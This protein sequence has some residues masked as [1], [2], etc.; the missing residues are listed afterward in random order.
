M[1]APTSDRKQQ[2]SSEPSPGSYSYVGRRST[3]PTGSRPSP[4][5]E[6]PPT[7]RRGS[8]GTP[9]S[10][11]QLRNPTSD[12]PPGDKQ[13][14]RAPRNP[15]VSDV[16]FDDRPTTPF[17]MGALDGRFGD[18]YVSDRRLDEVVLAFLR[19]EGL[20]SES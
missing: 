18:R 5:S 20:L 16:A 15:M 3:G 10:G 4:I 11:S 7:P 8:P 19:R 2:T 6:P 1:A 12:A 14:R 17:T 9:P 13:P